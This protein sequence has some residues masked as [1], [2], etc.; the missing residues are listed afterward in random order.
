MTHK[1]FSGNFRIFEGEIEFGELSENEMFCL[2]GIYGIKTGGQSIIMGPPI[3]LKTN[4]SKGESLDGGTSKQM[5]SND[6]VHLVR[7]QG[8]SSLIEE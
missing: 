7:F 8:V 1:T 4:E 6:K 3:F 2:P 5:Q